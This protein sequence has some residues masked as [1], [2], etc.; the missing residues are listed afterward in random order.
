MD[1]ESIGKFIQKR[2]IESG[3]TQRELGDKVFVTGKAVSKW[4]RGLSISDVTIL[5]KLA[6][7]L[8]KS[9]MRIIKE[10]K[11]NNTRYYSFCNFIYNCSI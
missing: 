5:E 11:E 8:K 2:R 3:L 6:D 10:L 1:Y 4:E 7:V 9:Y